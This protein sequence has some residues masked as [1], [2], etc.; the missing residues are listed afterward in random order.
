[1]QKGGLFEMGLLGA[2]Q[3]DARKWAKSRGTEVGVATGTDGGSV[4]VGNT[5][6]K[7]L[8]KAFMKNVKEMEIKKEVS[9][10]VIDAMAVEPAKRKLA[11]TPSSPTNEEIARHNETHLLYR[12]WCK[13]CVQGKAWQN[14]H[15]A[16]PVEVTERT[17]V[18]VDYCHMTCDEIA[19]KPNLTIFA[20][21][22]NRHGEVLSLLVRKKGPSD[23]YI[24]K[25]FAAWLDALDSGPVIVRSDAEPAIGDVVKEAVFQKGGKDRAAAVTEEIK[26]GTR[27]C[28]LRC[29]KCQLRTMSLR[30]LA[31]Y[32]SEKVSG[33][34]RLVAWMV[35]HCGWLLTR[36]QMKATGRTAYCSKMGR[37]YRREIVEFAEQVLFHISE[38]SGPGATV[39]KLMPRWDLGVCIGKINRLPKTSKWDTDFLQTVRELPWNPTETAVEKLTTVDIGKARR[40][41]ITRAMVAESGETLGCLGCTG[42]QK[43]HDENCRKT[44]ERIYLHTTAVPTPAAPI[45]E[46]ESPTGADAAEGAAA[47]AEP[48][49]AAEKEESESNDETGEAKCAAAAMS[50]KDVEIK[51]TECNDGTSGGP[52]GPARPQTEHESEVRAR[53]EGK[54]DELYGWS[55]Q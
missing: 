4:E 19:G 3:G 13:V 10:E 44:F 23:E 50:A 39:G 26:R 31:R 1:M 33:E 11:T 37:E 27:S 48:S 16:R 49:S 24:V 34:N 41:H 42:T 38:S 45:P 36:F 21:V 53:V 17:V 12:A 25:G 35:R 7:R 46:S 54:S 43:F 18:Q 55:Q 9:E 20:A 28:R 47:T 8:E 6:D 52:P 29:G 22:E 40:L 2:T 5:F 32:P 15:K 51:D 30:L 14:G